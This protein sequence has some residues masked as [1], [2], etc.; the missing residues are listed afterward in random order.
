MCLQTAGTSIVGKYEY[1][2]FHFQNEKCDCIKSLKLGDAKLP[3]TI[4]DSTS[5]AWQKAA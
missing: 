3:I 1:P 5:V 2:G 4:Q